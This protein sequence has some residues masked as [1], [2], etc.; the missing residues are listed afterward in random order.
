MKWSV[1]QTAF[2]QEDGV[3]IPSKTN[4][5][6]FSS[7]MLFLCLNLA[8]VL[9][10]YDKHIW[11]GLM[12]GR[13]CT[14]RKRVPC[15]P[16]WHAERPVTTWRNLMTRDENVLVNPFVIPNLT[17]LQLPVMSSVEQLG[18]FIPLQYSSPSSWSVSLTAMMNC[19]LSKPLKEVLHGWQLTLILL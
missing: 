18:G 10:F 17:S 5:A 2:T 8:K 19:F 4:Q 6:K 15:M 12:A 3:S 16:G 13:L 14:S 9:L 7:N 1:T 11:Q